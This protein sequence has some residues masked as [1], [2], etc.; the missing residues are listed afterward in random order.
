MTLL[1]MV[2]DAADQIVIPRPSTLIGSADPVSRLFLRLA[3]KEGKELAKRTNWQALTIEGSITTANGTASYVLPTA[4]DRI[5]EGSMFNRTQTKKVVGPIT[6]QRWQQL[7]ADGVTGV[8]QA[9]R[10]RA[11]YFYI[12]PTPTATESIYYEY[13]SKYWCSTTGET[14]PDQAA[15]V[16][17]TDIVYLPEEI[18]TLGLVWRFK[19]AR[20]LEYA[21]DY[22]T[23]EL[24]VAEAAGSDGGTGLLDLSADEPGTGVYEPST[25]DGSWSLS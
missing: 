11:G 9:F 15:F 17:D 18:M 21:E 1:S 2:Q 7:Q 12:T 22:Q 16:L 14:S 10:I 19:H 6:A 13:I 5:I 25:A 3:N 20:G 4:F 24:K 8:W 23:Y